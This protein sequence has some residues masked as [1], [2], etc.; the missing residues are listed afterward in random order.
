[1]TKWQ[2][3]RVAGDWVAE[4]EGRNELRSEVSEVLEAKLEVDAFVAGG[5]FSVVPIP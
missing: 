3:D 5:T 2:S 4:W 1:M